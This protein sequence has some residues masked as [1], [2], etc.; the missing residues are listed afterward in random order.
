TLTNA[1]SSA[2]REASQIGE[3]AQKFGVTTREMQTLAGVAEQSGVDL[4][5]L[6]DVM[7]DPGQRL[8]QGLRNPLSEVSQAP[9]ILDL[10]ARNPAGTVRTFPQL[11]PQ[12]ADGFARFKDGAEK[13]AIAAALFGRAAGPEMAQFLSQGSGS[14]DEMRRKLDETLPKFDVAPLQD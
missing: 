3:L 11:L 5:R 8:S 14:I 13:D 7:G 10:E 9:R 2:I 4:K 12:L 1:F 6:T